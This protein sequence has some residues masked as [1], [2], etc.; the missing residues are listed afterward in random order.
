M[1][2]EGTITL[3]VLMMSQLHMMMLQLLVRQHPVQASR[4]GLENTF[5]KKAASH[6]NVLNSERKENRRTQLSI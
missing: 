1:Y 4:N 3:A 5:I 6:L 2:G